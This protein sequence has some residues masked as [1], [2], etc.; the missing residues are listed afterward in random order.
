MMVRR[1]MDPALVYEIIGYIA[2]ALVA[3]S[4]MMSSILR[5]RIINMIGAAAFTLYGL[6]IGA[7]PV[8]VVN[9]IIV[10]I[11]LYYLYQIFG[12]EEYFTLLEVQPTS[13]YLRYFLGFYEDE[14]RTYL[15]EFAFDPEMPQIIFFVL[16]DL[17]PAGLFIAERWDESDLY[18]NL[19]FVIPGY[20]DFKIGAY[21]FTQRTAIFKDQGIERIYSRPGN[22]THQAYLRRMGFEPIIFEAQGELYCKEL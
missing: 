15:P 2:S 7:Y 8:A 10:V 6:L 21:I 11:D 20:R 17:V 13:D 12:E 14:I 22:T 19:D 4:L 5:L 18:V 1:P 9:F 16:R 3:I